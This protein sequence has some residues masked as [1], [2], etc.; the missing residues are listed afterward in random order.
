[1][2]N[3]FADTYI[4]QPGANVERQSGGADAL[5]FYHNAV[6]TGLFTSTA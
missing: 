5:H 1:M 2:A 6:L 3:S 4:R